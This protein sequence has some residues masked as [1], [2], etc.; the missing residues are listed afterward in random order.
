[1]NAR[2]VTLVVE[3]TVEGD[4][5]AAGWGGDL[6]ELAESLRATL[7][8][9]VGDDGGAYVPTVVV[10]PDALVAVYPNARGTVNP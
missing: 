9:L 4:D 7:G 8:E 2:R 3:V 1:M 5:L 6:A 10:R